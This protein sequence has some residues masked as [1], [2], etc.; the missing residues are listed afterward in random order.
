MGVEGAVRNCMAQLELN[1]LEKLEDIYQ[2]HTIHATIIICETEDDALSLTKRMHDND[3]SVDFCMN[4]TG[5]HTTQL[6]GPLQS[7]SKQEIKVLVLPYACWYEYKSMI[8]PF[9]GHHNLLVFY[10]LENQLQYV[11]TDWLT[12]MKSRGFLDAQSMD[13]YHVLA[14]EKDPEL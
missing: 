11:V 4:D 13:H 10:G 8:E 7:F 6:H 12:D 3:H 2:T 5:L 14:V 9:V 1:A